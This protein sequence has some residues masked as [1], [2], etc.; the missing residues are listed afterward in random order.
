M[1]FTVVT[2]VAVVTVQLVVAHAH[3]CSHESVAQLY[4]AYTALEAVNVVEQPQTLY[5]HGSSSS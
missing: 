2:R 4:T 3:V 5:D 1:L